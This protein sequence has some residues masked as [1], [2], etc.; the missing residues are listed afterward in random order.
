MNFTLVKGHYK[1][2]FTFIPGE[3]NEKEDKYCVTQYQFL[4]GHLNYVPYSGKLVTA[5]EGNRLMM[6]LEKE[7]YKYA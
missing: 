3:K 7:N 1:V 2:E 4:P 5:K 6:R